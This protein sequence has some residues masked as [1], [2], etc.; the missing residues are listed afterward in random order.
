ME[1]SSVRVRRSGLAGGALIL[2]CGFLGYIVIKQF[3]EYGELAAIYS[4]LGIDKPQV[5]GFVPLIPIAA[6]AISALLGA[7]GGLLAERHGKAAGLLMIAGAVFCVPCIFVFISIAP[8]VLFILGA[9]KAL[10]KEPQSGDG[11]SI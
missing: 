8:A 4:S 2:F 6:G 11:K 10:R 1:S 5:S 3:I 9:S 7:A